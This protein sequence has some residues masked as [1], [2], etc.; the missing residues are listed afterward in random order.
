MR[1][2]VTGVSGYIGSRLVPR[3]LADGHEVR[4]LSRRPRPG[5]GVP[6]TQ[7]DAATGAGLER[8]LQDIEVAYFLIHAMEPS[9][10]GPFA[11]RER[12][13]AQNFAAAAAAAGTRRIVYLGGLIPRGGPASAHL[14]SRLAVEE[15]L[16]SAVPC[17][18]ALRASVVIGA[19]SASF[20]LLVRLI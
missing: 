6:V 14:A 8:A 9:T 17:S 13:A 20:R 3:L 7:A 5:L 2:L 11:A 12:V 16:R 1:I 10:N 19:G 15:I 18:V 4:G